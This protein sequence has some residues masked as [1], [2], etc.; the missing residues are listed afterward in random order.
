[1]LAIVIRVPSIHSGLGL[2]WM[3]AWLLIVLEFQILLELLL[4]LVLEGLG[5]LS[6]LQVLWSVHPVLIAVVS[7]MTCFVLLCFCDGVMLFVMEG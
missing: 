2:Q 7:R 6:W 1:V 4:L 5:V 3:D